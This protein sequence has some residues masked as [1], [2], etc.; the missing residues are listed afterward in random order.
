MRRPFLPLIIALISGLVIP[1]KLK[2]TGLSLF[3]LLGISLLAFLIFESKI[4]G[5]LILVFLL[6]LSLGIYENRPMDLDQS[7]CTI[8]ASI[9]D[10]ERESETYSRYLVRTREIDNR[11][12]KENI[13]VSYFGKMDLSRGDSISLRA[14]LKE[15]LENTNPGGFNY[16]RYLNSKGI[17]VVAEVD[18]GELK[19]RSKGRSSQSPLRFEK[20]LEDSLKALSG[21][22]KKLLKSIILGRTDHMEE[23]DLD[24]FRGLGLAHILAVSGL[25]IGVIASF[26]RSL[27]IVFGMSINLGEFIGIIVLLYYGYLIG[28]PVSVLR[29]ISMFTLKF[30][31]VIKEK[32]YDSINI[33]LGIAFIFLI[34]KPYLIYNLSFQL[35]FLACLSIYYIGSK[36]RRH[37]IR[38]D[39][40]LAKALCLSLSVSIGL[41]PLQI[42]YF[43]NYNF[44]T[45]FANIIVV[46]IISFIIPLV[47][48]NFFIFR[49]FKNLSFGFLYLVSKLL[50][51]VFLI[52]DKLALVSIFSV[53]AAFGGT[54]FRLYIFIFLIVFKL[55]DL[56][57]LRPELRKVLVYFTIF[58]MG[59]SLVSYDNK[60]ISIDFID[61]GQGDAILLSD[62]K[63]KN[64]IDTG[65]SY[66]RDVGKNDLG[67]YLDYRSIDRLDRVFISHFDYDHYGSL[68]YLLENYKISKI[69]INRWPEDQDLKELLV[70]VSKASTEIKLLKAGDRID[71]GEGK[72]LEVVDRSRDYLDENNNSMVLRGQF[73]SKS[74]LFTG[75][76]EE[77]RERELVDQLSA[78][79]F[80]KL[81]HH[82]SDSSSSQDFI[83]LLRPKVSIISVGRNNGFG[84]PSKEVLDRLKSVGTRIYRTDEDGLISLYIGEKTWSIDAYLKDRLSL[85]DLLYANIGELAIYL[86]F[87]L[88]SRYLIIIYMRSCN[89]GLQNTTKKYKG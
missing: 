81:G 55:I 26:T 58:S 39:G 12:R 5:Y 11:E 28:F 47:F 53:R 86:L 57:R 45:I 22:K 42:Y 72:V 71:L 79:D 32:Y 67:P 29:A 75:D 8:E 34:F 48:I 24:S 6:G 83:D 43:R 61:V 63:T 4:R 50:N 80:L 54:Y 40:Y 64:L 85:E 46:P 38:G 68:V 14:S 73:F 82:G 84:H 37:Y 74:I 78:V 87:L 62:N 88:A 23:E 66:F 59:L 2:I 44:L 3:L 65:G 36:L 17:K 1:G 25:H 19:L 16:K 31:S 60:F 69:Y 89:F 77:E 18:K 33:L 30:I 27:V 15:P 70:K 21:R 76:I 10:I 7:K 9:V 20:R 51:L 52:V 49:R 41:M 56:N 13:L 35:S